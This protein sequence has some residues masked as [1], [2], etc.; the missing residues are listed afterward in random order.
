LKP[1]LKLNEKTSLKCL[2]DIFLDMCLLVGQ[3]QTRVQACPNGC[4]QKNN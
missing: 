3:Q 1:L 4:G 2:A